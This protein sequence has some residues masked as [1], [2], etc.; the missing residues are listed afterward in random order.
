L[1]IYEV[2]MHKE[3]VFVSNE[4]KVYVDV[5]E[6]R[7]KEGQLIPLNLVWEDGVSY[8]IDRVLDARPAASLKAGGSGMRYTVRIRGRE[9]SMFLEEND[10][11]ARWFIERKRV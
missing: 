7:T 1:D 3:Q 5:T 6:R 8:A 10:G 9:T 2:I 4:F 11:E